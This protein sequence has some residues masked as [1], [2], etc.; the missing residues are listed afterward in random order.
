M[1]Y[2]DGQEARLGDIARGKGYNVKDEKGELKEITG[3]VVKLTEGAVS[4]NLVIAHLIAGE[5]KDQ[6]GETLGVFNGSLM[7][8]KT[9]VLVAAEYG[10]CD[11]FE[12]VERAKVQVI[13][14]PETIVEK[15]EEVAREV[16][17]G[18]E[19]AA[20][21]L[22]AELSGDPAPSDTTPVEQPAESTPAEVTE[23]PAP[24]A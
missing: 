8:E 4:C 20:I 1:H 21:D 14:K 18:V 15:A 3:V 2:K 16:A 12:L 23:Q 5:I 6:D 13:Q 24:A 9:P 17:E 22:A 11:H 19:K 10:Q 7:V